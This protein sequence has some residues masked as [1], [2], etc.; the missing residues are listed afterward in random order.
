MEECDIVFGHFLL[1]SSIFINSNFSVFN[2]AEKCGLFRMLRLASRSLSRST[3][4]SQS[5]KTDPKFGKKLGNIGQF[6]HERTGVFAQV[7]PTLT[8]PYAG[9]ELLNDIIARHCP[10]E[11]YNMV[12]LDLHQFG[13]RIVME[14]DA[15][16][17]ECEANPPRLRRTDAWGQRIDEI[18]CTRAWYDQ[19]RISAEEGL[20]AIGYERKS[21]SFSRVHQMA[22]NLLYGSSSG[23]YN[24]PLAMTDGAAM[25]TQAQKEQHPFLSQPFQNLTSRDPEKFWTSGQWMT[26]KAGGSD[27]G[28][29]THTEAVWNSEDEV[30]ELFGYKWFTSAI[31]SDMTLTLARIHDEDDCVTSGTRGLS[32]F[33][34]TV[35]EKSGKLNGI[36]VHKMKEKLGTRQLPTAELILEGTKAQLIGEP[37]RGINLITGMLTVTRIHNAVAACSAMRRMTQLARDYATRRTAFKTKLS[38]HQAHVST[39]ARMEIETRAAMLLTLEVSRLFGRVELNEATDREKDLM[40]ILTPLTKLQTAKQAV[41]ICSEGLECFGGQGYIE[42]TQMPRLFRDS[43]VLP[44]WEGNLNFS[45]FF[46]ARLSL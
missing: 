17:D 14:V 30:F 11:Q 8:N 37:G 10:A 2:K 28:D 21:G 13:E 6:Q 29:G 9:D 45:L 43:Q 44:I 4:C 12:N 35:R 15:L 34:L 46:D 42:E 36:Q 41:A 5:A 33:Y 24:C 16:G 38:N 19:H 26:E 27:V 23:L 22:K 18:V 40:R 20:I 25:I 3:P 7:K 1:R 32:M 31:T 39:L